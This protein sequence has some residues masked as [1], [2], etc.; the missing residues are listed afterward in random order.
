MT[1]QRFYLCFTYLN[2]FPMIIHI[3]NEFFRCFLCS[4]KKKN[5]L[6]TFTNYVKIKRNHSETWQWHIM[7]Y[8]I[9]NNK[10]FTF[11]HTVFVLLIFEPMLL[12]ICHV[13]QTL[14]DIGDIK[15]SCYFKA[16]SCI[17]L[18]WLSC[19]SRLIGK[20]G[21]TWSWRCGQG[22]LSRSRAKPVAVVIEKREWM[23]EI[24]GQ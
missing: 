13:P 21:W 2:T 24:L 9:V 14:P 10:W 22:P 16:G 11:L 3:L 23:Q 17:Q 15:W 18:I 7:L 5:S 19:F 12:S 20:I 1:C 8:K 4:H 6:S